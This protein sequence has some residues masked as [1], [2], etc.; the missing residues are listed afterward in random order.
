MV[1]EI[2]VFPAFMKQSIVTETDSN[3]IN[4]SIYVCTSCDME[5]KKEVL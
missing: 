2:D 3:Q 1:S 5:G 4:T